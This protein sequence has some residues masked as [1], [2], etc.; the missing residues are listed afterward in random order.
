MT[1]LGGRG[2]VLSV[3]SEN[4][5]ADQ[6]CGYCTADLRLCFHIHVC[7]NLVISGCGSNGIRCKNC[8]CTFTV[9]SLFTVY[10]Y[11]L[12]TVYAH[13]LRMVQFKH[14]Y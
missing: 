1:D 5:G 9:Y 3:F 10:A 4:K 6:L 11:L 7:K 2:I 14:I 8:A 13:L 12:S